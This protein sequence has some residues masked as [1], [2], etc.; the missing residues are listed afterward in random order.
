MGCIEGSPEEAEL[1]AIGHAIEAHKERQAGREN[2]R[3][4][5]L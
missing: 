2:T 3:R 1:K 5:G 4:K